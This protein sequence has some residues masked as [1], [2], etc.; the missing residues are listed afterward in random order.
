M[1]KQIQSLNVA[2][3]IAFTIILFSIVE[4]Q[5]ILKNDAF[6]NSYSFATPSFQQS[7]TRYFGGA[8]NANLQQIQPNQQSFNP[9]Q[10]FKMSS[11]SNQQQLAAQ[12]VSHILH[13]QRM[14]NIYHQNNL[15]STYVS[16]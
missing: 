10:I 14:E 2:A 1:T 13:Q 5:L 9:Q 11:F 8:N 4:C 3:Y 16:K 15:R 12:D 6:S 7:F